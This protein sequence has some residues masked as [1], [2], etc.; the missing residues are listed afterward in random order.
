MN[1]VPVILATRVATVL[2]RVWMHVVVVVTVVNIAACA[3]CDA[4]MVAAHDTPINT[5]I[6]VSGLAEYGTHH[7][8]MT[9]VSGHLNDADVVVIKSLHAQG[10][11]DVM[12]RRVP[13]AQLTIFTVSTGVDVPLIT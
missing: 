13:V 11:V 10:H 3:A 7:D 9:T 8:R 6:R 12:I 1:Q 5:R 4:C 2:G